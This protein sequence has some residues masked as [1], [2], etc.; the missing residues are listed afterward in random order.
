MLVDSPLDSNGIY[1][2]PCETNIMV[3][4]GL[5]IGTEDTPYYG[6]YYFFKFEFPQT[7]PFQPPKV[8]FLTQGCKF[9]FHPNLYTDGKVCLSIL[10]TWPGES[11]TPCNTI[12]STLLSIAMLLSKNAI[13]NEPGLS[14]AVDVT[15]KKYDA[16]VFYNNVK[17]AICSIIEKKEGV[18]KPEFDLF[19]A[20]I[21]TNFLKHKDKLTEL[22]NKLVETDDNKPIIMTEYAISV[23][24]NYSELKMRLSECLKQVNLELCTQQPTP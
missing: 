15:C 22:I 8:T 12:G 23:I 19:R 9:R 13:H 5:I 20:Q 3:G 6:G 7:Y 1:Y 18:Y 10:G 21:L 14:N 2:M 11:W 24:Q 4:Y 16:V 17:T